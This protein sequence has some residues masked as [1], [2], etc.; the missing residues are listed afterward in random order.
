MINTDATLLRV[1]VKAGSGVEEKQR[2]KCRH[3]EKTQ[4]KK[5]A[6]SVSVEGIYLC[7]K[8]IFFP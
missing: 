8:E 1:V 5:T 4:V 7:L 3:R 2:S 6:V